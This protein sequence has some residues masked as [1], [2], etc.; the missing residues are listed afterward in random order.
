MY[1]LSVEEHQIYRAP[2]CPKC[3]RSLD[4]IEVERYSDSILWDRDAG[5]YELSS[6]VPAAVYVCPY[7]R[8]NIGG[9][10]RNGR[11]WGFDPAQANAIGHVKL[12]EKE[13]LEKL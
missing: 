4:R 6:R 8:E 9:R 3:Q 2:S 7:C 13:I 10:L 1:E 5:A 11:K 12:E